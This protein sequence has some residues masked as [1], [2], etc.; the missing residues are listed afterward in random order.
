[1]SKV[2]CTVLAHKPRK[3]VKE[4]RDEKTLRTLRLMQKTVR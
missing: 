4:L 2:E 1:M 3:S